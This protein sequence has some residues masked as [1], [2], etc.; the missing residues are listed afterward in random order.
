M[1]S[2]T[3]QGKLYGYR[4]CCTLD[5]VE[6]V[7]LMHV[8]NRDHTNNE[9]IITNKLIGTQSLIAASRSTMYKRL[10]RHEASKIYWR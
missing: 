7:S 2:N 3:Y 1:E 10:K 6:S 9:S 8:D 4:R 5:N